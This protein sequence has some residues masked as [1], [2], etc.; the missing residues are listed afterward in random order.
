MGG[1][2]NLASS[3]PHNKPEIRRMWVPDKAFTFSIFSICKNY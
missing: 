3:L 1:I 2:L